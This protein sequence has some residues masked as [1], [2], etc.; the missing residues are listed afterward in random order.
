LWDETPH[1]ASGV[2]AAIS[3][4]NRMER[5]QP[6]RVNRAE[7]PAFQH[8][9]ATPD[10]TGNLVASACHGSRTSWL[11]AERSTGYRSAP[12]RHDAEQMNYFVSGEM[13]LFIE[14]CGYLCGAG[15]IVC[16]PPGKWHWAVNRSAHPCVMIETHSPPVTNDQIAR[17]TV[18]LLGPDED[19]RTVEH[20]ESESA[21][22][23]GD[24]RAIEARALAEHAAGQGDRT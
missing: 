8:T 14:D 16:I 24:V 15:D 10:N 1:D 19:P 6:Y 13:W 4:T 9:P 5:R 22:Y 21:Q 11:F 17:S 12:H 7:L 20:R 3:E 18:G 2:M 23:S